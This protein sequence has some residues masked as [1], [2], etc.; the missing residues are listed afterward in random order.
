VKVR[1]RSTLPEDKDRDLAKIIQLKSMFANDPTVKIAE[2][3]AM[4][5]ELA[6]FDSSRLVQSPDEQQATF[7]ALREEGVLNEKPANGSG[8]GGVDANF[9]RMLGRQ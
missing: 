1:A 8:G 6:G 5:L 3:N 4:M 7:D 9:I 2:M